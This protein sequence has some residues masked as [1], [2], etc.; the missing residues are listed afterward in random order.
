M[1][2]V[3]ELAKFVTATSVADLGPEALEQLKIRIL[4]TLGVAI[5]ALDA[6]PIVAIRALLDDLGGSPTSTLIGGGRTSPERAAFFNSAL[7]RYLDFMDAYLAKGETCHP[8]DNLGAV[9]AAAESVNASGAELLV[10]LAVAYQVHTRL[11]DVAPVRAKG[12]D[13]TTQGAF[14]AAAGAARAMRLSTEQTANAIAI[15]GTANVALRVTRTGDLSHWKGLAYPHVSKE[16]TFAALLAGRG[17]TGPQA[18]FEGNKG[19]KESVSGPFEIDWSTENL[20][21]VRRTI[22]KKHNAEIHSQSA[23]DAAQAIREQAGFRAAAIGRVHL[24]TFDVAHSI[25]GGGEEGDKLAVRTKEEADHS[26]PWM[27]A[28]VLLDGRLTPTQ[29]APERIVAE[30]VQTLMRKV[31]IVPEDKLSARFPDEMPAELEVT[32]ADGTI[33]RSS[34]NA[35]EGFHTRPLSR[36]G[37][38]AKFDTLSLSFADEALREEIADIVGD[39]EHRK[40]SDLVAALARV[41]RRRST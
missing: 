32:L 4:D 35:Y 24:R 30:D 40:T 3:Q 9:L 28:V 12:F 8:S 34:K 41:S 2:E 14:A 16:G 37:A 25:I 7:S 11:S 17:I 31:E 21:R 39:L 6:E 13:H 26:L 1:T 18:V 5:G 20:E 22:I 36:A 10:A 19:F 29:Y 23:L 15:A 38:R 33:L 27:L